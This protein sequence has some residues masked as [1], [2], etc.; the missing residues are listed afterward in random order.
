MN[1]MIQILKK[2]KKYRNKLNCTLRLA[3]QNY[4]CDLLKS[5]KNNMRNTWKIINSIIR[6]K[7]NT[8]SEKFVSKNST[9]TCPKE[10]ATEFNRYFANIGPSSA[11]TIQ[12]SGKNYSSYLQNSNS[13]T[14]FFKPTDEAEITKLI[15][16]LGSRK[17]AGHDGIKSDV[18]KMV[19]NEISYPLKL[20]FNKSLA[21]GSVPDELKIAKVVPIYKKDTWENCLYSNIWFSNQKWNSL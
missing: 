13:K 14:C 18:I 19:A 16:K 2:F 3:K 20:L 15:K 6:S 9:I 17:S 11:S 12:H 10:I 4:Y 5:E 7:S 8:Y 21:N 1:L